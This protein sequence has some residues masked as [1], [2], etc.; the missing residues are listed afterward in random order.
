MIIASPPSSISAE[1]HLV[2]LAG[3]GMN[4]LS[5]AAS[6]GSS[7]LCWSLRP[8]RN[9]SFR[10]DVSTKCPAVCP[11][12]RPSSALTGRLVLCVGTRLYLLVCPSNTSGGEE[13]THELLRAQLQSLNTSCRKKVK[14]AEKWLCCEMNIQHVCSYVLACGSSV[15][16]G[17]CSAEPHRLLLWPE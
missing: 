6:F 16:N 15:I 4:I 13:K 1:M 3:R 9:V 2:G 17:A 8:A 5:G 11:L 7:L 12:R 14:Q 10:L